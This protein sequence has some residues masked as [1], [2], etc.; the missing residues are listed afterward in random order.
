MVLNEVHPAPLPDPTA[1]PAD[2]E[3]LRQAGT[4]ALAA[5][6]IVDAELRAVARQALAR[7]RLGAIGVPVA[8]LPFLYRRNLGRAELEGFAERVGVLT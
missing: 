2:R 7:E 5:T 6:S 3:R 8:E 4:D 1:W